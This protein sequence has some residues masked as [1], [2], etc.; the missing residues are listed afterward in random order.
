MPLS[1][2]ALP[3]GLYQGGVDLLLTLRAADLLEV[4]L[5]CFEASDIG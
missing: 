5:T 2:G 4:R 3:N 1:K